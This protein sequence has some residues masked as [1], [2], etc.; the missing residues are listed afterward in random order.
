MK[1]K[2]IEVGKEYRVIVPE[3]VDAGAFWDH[4]YGRVPVYAT[5]IEVGI[6]YDVPQYET[7]GGIQGTPR[8]L[9]RYL[10]SERADGVALTL[11]RG[12]RVV[13]P[14]RNVQYERPEYTR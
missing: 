5:V 1:L 13:I 9:K 7:Y 12:K 4:R 11:T 8:V 14:C 6:H 2:D 3:H 10:T